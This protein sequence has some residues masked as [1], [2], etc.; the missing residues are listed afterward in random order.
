MSNVHFE[1]LRVN[2]SLEIALFSM[3]KIAPDELTG[4]QT[5]S[6]VNATSGLQLTTVDR[7]NSNELVS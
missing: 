7:F 4:G 1:C 5:D 6:D 2:S 3:F